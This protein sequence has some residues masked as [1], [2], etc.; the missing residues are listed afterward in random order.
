MFLTF[1]SDF[2]RVIFRRIMNTMG[3]V[4]DAISMGRFAGTE[5]NYLE[6]EAIIAK[7][8]EEVKEKKEKQG[9]FS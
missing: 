2:F 3:R 8:V 1:F 4:A 6:H 5:D 7:K 9:M